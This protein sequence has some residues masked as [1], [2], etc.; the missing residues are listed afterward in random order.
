MEPPVNKPP[1]ARPEVWPDAP[2][3]DAM[4]RRQA[5]ES[6]RLARRYAPEH[7]PVTVPEGKGLREAAV[8]AQQS[9]DVDGAHARLFTS[10][11]DSPPASA[12]EEAPKRR[13]R[14]T[15]KTRRLGGDGDA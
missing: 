3:T 15:R 14:T 9:F 11:E 6:L 13:R 2:P 4:K 12:V 8:R 10:Q 1:L 7:T 5:W